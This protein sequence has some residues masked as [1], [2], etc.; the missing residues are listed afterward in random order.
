MQ[1]WHHYNT[2]IPMT[3]LIKMGTYQGTDILYDLE[4]EMVS[5]TAMWRAAGEGN[6]YRNPTEWTRK[7][8][9]AVIASIS[10][11]L[12]TP[13]ERIVKTR[14]GG[15]G[16]GG[17]TWA[18]RRIALAYGAYLNPD[19]HAL[20]L[21]WAEER[22]EEEANPDLAYQR[23]RERAVEGYKRRGWSEERIAQ[24]LQG[25]DTRK[26]F[27]DKLQQ[28]GVEGQ[29]YRECTDAIYD[30]VLGGTAKELRQQR[31]LPTKANVRD[32]LDTDE[33]SAVSF[34]EVVARK[35]LDRR[36]AQG[37]HQCKQVCEQTGSDVGEAIR[38]L[39]E[40]E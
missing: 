14:K 30:G 11:E 13:Q 27:T 35:R 38:K 24:R 26:A 4:T 15:K 34:A 6:R 23:G 28:H 1:E 21:K 33:L 8:G 2:E 5:L 20:I 36:Q 22:M 9:K 25:I 10:R 31:S 18:H 29:G 3:T 19:L 37:N 40:G 7:E 39:L 32:N 12:D 17:G 16:G